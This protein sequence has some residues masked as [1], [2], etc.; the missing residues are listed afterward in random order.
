MVDRTV[1]I[2][3][4]RTI[5]DKSK[6]T[7]IISTDDLAQR[8]VEMVHGGA[9]GVD[10]TAKEI[11]EEHWDNT[12]ITCFEPDWEEHGK[13]AGPIRN[14]EM[15]EYADSLIAI[16]DGESSGTRSMIEKALDE[17]LD[18]HIYNLSKD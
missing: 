5:D 7:S 9:K 15:A 17:N 10:Q 6:L 8:M 13:A 16:W 14:Q 1:I 4:S 11:V 18:I 2:A 3:G 12:E